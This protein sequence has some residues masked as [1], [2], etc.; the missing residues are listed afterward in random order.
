M[1]Q[2]ACAESPL[3]GTR[4][5]GEEKE[6]GAL[7]AHCIRRRTRRSRLFGAPVP[8]QALGRGLGCRGGAGAGINAEGLSGFR[9]QLAAAAVAAT[10]SDLLKS[11]YPTPGKGVGAARGETRSGE[12]RVSGGPPLIAGAGRPGGGKSRM[13]PGHALSSGPRWAL[14]TENLR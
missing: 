9:S 4:L 7:E 13:L 2:S 10:S 11:C 1:P 5:G 12:G 3:S 14:C 8:A 6:R